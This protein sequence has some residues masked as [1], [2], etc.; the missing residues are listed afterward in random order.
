[1]SGA[2]R[3]SMSSSMTKS[4]ARSSRIQSPWPRWNST[5]GSSGHVEA[6]HPEVVAQQSIRCRDIV[7]VGCAEHQERAVAEE[8]ELASRPQQTGGLGDPDIRVGPDRG[9]VLAD[10]EVERPGAQ[11]DLF[12]SGTDEREREPSRDL[13]AA[14]DLELRGRGVHSEGP[15]ATPREPRG[16]VRRAAAELDRGHPVEIAPGAVRPLTRGSRRCPT[17][18][19]SVPTSVPRTAAAPR[20]GQPTIRCCWRG[21]RAV[22][23]SR[24]PYRSA[25]TFVA[26]RSVGDLV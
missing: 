3:S 9:A 25:H 10:D 1:M 13:L 19:R 2:G 16:H 20:A 21:G 5:V 17:S 4:F 15:S 23:A 24:R 12:A 11:R 22:L 6:M 14:S 18:V 8:D 26:D 7:L